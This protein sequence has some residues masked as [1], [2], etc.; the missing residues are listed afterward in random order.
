MQSTSIFGLKQDYF[1]FQPLYPN[2]LHSINYS[3]NIDQ[4]Y[5]YTIDDKLLQCL[6]EILSLMISWKGAVGST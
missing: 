1:K 4:G 2:N 6:V 3:Y 5:E